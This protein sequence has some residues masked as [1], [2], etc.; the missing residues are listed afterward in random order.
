MSSHSSEHSVLIALRELDCLEMQRRDAEAAKERA[1]AAAEAEARAAAEARAQAEAQA[2]AHALA[3]AEAAAEAERA[4]RAHVQRLHDIEVEARL[5]AEQAARLHRVQAEIDVQLR[6][7]SRREL[8]GQR[9]VVAVLLAVLGL[10]GAL[11]AMVLTR[12]SAGLVERAV[13]SADDLQHMAALEE[14]AAVIAG[15]ER[16][17]GRIRD[18]NQ[19]QEAV[20]EAAAALR[21]MMQ[22]PTPKDERVTGLRP[23]PVRPKPPPT[24][25]PPVGGGVKICDVDDPLAE[26]C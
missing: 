10:A 13:A 3:E 21:T 26:D 5:K 7:H 20:L 25:K 9:V 8:A 24:A 2:R 18:D 15:M 16:D 1:R 17:L 22:T 12:P 4:R 19:R 6:S 11:G 14:Y 23:K